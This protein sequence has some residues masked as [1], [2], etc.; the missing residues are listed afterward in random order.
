MLI[1]HL[2][3]SVDQHQRRNTPKLEQVDFLSIKI[4]ND[5]FRIGQA[6]KWQM[7]VFP[8]THKRF[9]AVG[10]NGQDN[11]VTRG[12]GRKI[13]AQAREMSAAVRS[14]KSAQENQ[15]DIFASFE[16]RKTHHGAI[17]ISKF[18]IRCKRK[19]FHILPFK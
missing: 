5:M 9:G 18:K 14:Q 15:N 10:A 16:L 4:G 1:T 13:I 11:R 19:N 12:E 3:F 8:V 6:D 17:H 7:F 2:A